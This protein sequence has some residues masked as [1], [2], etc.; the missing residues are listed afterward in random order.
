MVCSEKCVQCLNAS[1]LPPFNLILHWF[2]KR[3]KWTN[4]ENWSKNWG[5][6]VQHVARYT[7]QCHISSLSYSEPR[8]NTS[9]FFLNSLITLLF[10]HL[11]PG[12]GVPV[13]TWLKVT[14][15]LGLRP[16][17]HGPAVERSQGPL[18]P[19]VK[20]LDLS[21]FNAAFAILR[22]LGEDTAWMLFKQHELLFLTS[23]GD[24]KATGF[25]VC[26]FNGP[27]HSSS[28]MSS[29]TNGTFSYCIWIT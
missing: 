23:S 8:E 7:L 13:E 1:L 6:C 19:H 9:A 20:T 28:E 27:H 2:M 10:T 16:G 17:G 18:I 12:G 24:S 15:R 29:R 5:F 11:T 25:A 22:A 21:W 14:G 4:S 26:G 3:H